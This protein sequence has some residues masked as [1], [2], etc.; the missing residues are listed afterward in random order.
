MMQPIFQSFQSRQRLSSIT[1]PAVC[2]RIIIGEFRAVRTETYWSLS[3][4]WINAEANL[5]SHGYEHAANT[6]IRRADLSLSL[7][8]SCLACNHP[9]LVQAA[10]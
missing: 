10:A 4:K 1:R 6:D 5:A 3:V 2:N 9:V 7:F 8:I